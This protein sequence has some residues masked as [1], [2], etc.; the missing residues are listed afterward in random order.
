M[1]RSRSTRLFTLCPAVPKLSLVDCIVLECLIVSVVEPEAQFQ[2][3][4]S[5]LSSIVSPY[6][7][8]FVFQLDPRR[9]PHIRAAPMLNDVSN[10]ISRLDRSLS[11]LAHRAIRNYTKFLFVLLT[12]N[13]LELVQGLTMLNL[14]GDILVGE[15]AVGGDHVCVYISAST[16]LR[17]A[18]DGEAG[19]PCDVYDFI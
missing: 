10:P 5:T 11:V 14:E 13:A 17:K 6:F 1:S 3:I 4:D 2:R 18:L 15:K 16:P 7:C 8:K 9:F 19:T 12:P